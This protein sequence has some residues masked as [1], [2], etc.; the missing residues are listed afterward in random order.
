MLQAREFLCILLLV[1]GAIW[2][3]YLY[4]QSTEPSDQQLLVE[5]HLV[6]ARAAV[7]AGK[8]DQ[9]PDDCAWSHYRAAQDID[10]GNAEALQ[11]LVVVQKALISRA[12]DVAREMD[13]ELAER[14]LEEAALVRES[15]ELPDAAEEEIFA[16]R[17][18]YA[19]DLEVRAVQAMDSGNFAQAEHALI[20]MIALGGAG[21]TVSQLR[22][23]L[24]EARIYG[25]FRPGQIIRE[26]F[27]NQ[28]FWTPESVVVLAG[29]YMMGSSAFEDGRK[30][31]EGPRHRV[32]FRRG[33]AMGRTEVTV[34]EFRMFARQTGYRSDARQQGHSTIYNHQS[35]RLAKRD[36]V[37]WEMNYEGKKAKDNE[38][39]VHVSWNDAMA[40]VQWLA[41]GTGKSYRL[42]TEAEFEYALRGGQTGRYWWGDGAPP[43]MVENLTGELDV[44]RG[45]RQWSTYFEGYKDGYWGPAPVASFVTNP[46]GLHDMAGNVGEWVR[47]CW[48]D[49]YLRAPV[50]GTAWL[51]PGC[52]L[53]TIRGGYWASSPDQVRS[54]FRLSAQADRRDA[55]IGIRIARDL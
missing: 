45:R 4:A 34:K 18:Q 53:R 50:D 49:T 9:P 35:G 42:P 8:I 27:I 52:K 7:R 12:I 43:K 22:Q 30:D 20:E 40:Y 19:E 51:N 1:A 23:R 26:S 3:G 31:N 5:R 16:F 13:F 33:F 6:A 44:S 28:G 55:R 46:F 38:P 39:V 48:H 21:S 17:S 14:M 37:N 29:S 47:D 25:G 10:P 41:R 32:M 15:R 11:G 36:D 54:A 24:E 2:G